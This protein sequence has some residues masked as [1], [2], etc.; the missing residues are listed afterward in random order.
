MVVKRSNMQNKLVSVCKFYGI[1][2]KTVIKL[3]LN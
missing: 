3:L 1:S 2:I